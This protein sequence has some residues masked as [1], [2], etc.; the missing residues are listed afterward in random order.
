MA[1][2]A[3]KKAR[4]YANRQRKYEIAARSKQARAN[5]AARSVTTLKSYD[6][7]TISKLTDRQLI[8][9]ANNLGK[10]QERVK[11]EVMRRAQQQYYNVP[12][13]IVTKKDRMFAARPAITDAEI[14]AAPSGRRHTLR[15]QQRRRA[16]A[17]ATIK[18]AQENERLQAKRTIEQQRDRERYGLDI[19]ETGL[20]E[21][22]L[23]GNPKYR[24]LMEMTNV[25]NDVEFV[26]DMKRDMLES[27]VLDAAERMNKPHKGRNRRKAKSYD[28]VQWA[29]RGKDGSSQR[30]RYDNLDLINRLGAISVGTM[31]RYRHLSQWE[32]D[33]LEEATSFRQVATTV[34]GSPKGRNRQGMGV[35]VFDGDYS[36]REEVT[37]KLNDFMDMAKSYK[38]NKAESTRRKSEPNDFAEFFKAVKKYM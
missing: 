22:V 8:A 5:Q 17:K 26:A 25:L 21:K 34:T 11:R 33:F 38:P 7:N 24:A 20:S 13:I 3:S 35:Y 1:R 15:Q 2:K 31:N 32:K 29:K 27:E 4:R 30:K 28:N 14:E 9:V 37:T 12:K 36:E 16:Q 19:D 18:K 10:E 23:Q 6:E